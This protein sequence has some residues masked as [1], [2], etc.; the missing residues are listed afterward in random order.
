M[1]TTPDPFEVRLDDLS[2]RCDALETTIGK[3]TAER[4]VAGEE[5]IYR[6][7]IW[8]QLAAYS[9]ADDRRIIESIFLDGVISPGDLKITPR[10]EGTNLSVDVAPGH[11]VVLGTEQADQG[12]YLCPLAHR[13]NL[14]LAAGPAA[15]QSRF[16]LIVA[17]VIESSDP[18]T[19]TDW[20]VEVVR[21][22]A[23]T[24]PGV[25]PAPAS[26]YPLAVVGPIAQGTASITANLIADRR[27]ISRPAPLGGIHEQTRWMSGLVTTEWLIPWEPA[28]V[29]PVMPWPTIVTAHFNGSVRADRMAPTVPR[30][31]LRHQLAP[32]AGWIQS[33]S[34]DRSEHGLDTRSF[35]RMDVFHLAAGQGPCAVQPIVGI[36]YDWGSQAGA[37]WTNCQLT[38]QMLPR[39]SLVT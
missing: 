37:I 28:E 31:G 20:A 10:A 38:V 5:V 27:H 6:P 2:L 9:A 12:R 14:A 18:D 17:H 16:D 7:P 1:T 21:G 29:L 19:P 24:A 33:Q 4:A 32:G 36:D 13:V 3:L 23:S 8:S 25:P 26:S 34:L 11:V 22:E 30:T 35:H 15:G 39:G